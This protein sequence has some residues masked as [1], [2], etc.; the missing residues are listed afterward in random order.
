MCKEKSKSF[1]CFFDLKKAYNHE[2]QCIIR[3]IRSK[4][5][6]YVNWDFIEISSNIKAHWRSHNGMLSTRN[7][8]TLNITAVKPHS[9]L[10]IAAPTKLRSVDTDGKGK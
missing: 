8:S 5:L 4:F 2:H 1:S 10:P 3:M 7:F 6:S 9:I